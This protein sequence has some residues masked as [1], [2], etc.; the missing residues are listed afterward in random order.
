MKFQPHERIFYDILAPG[1][2]GEMGLHYTKEIGR[3]GAVSGNS[4]KDYS[5]TYRSRILTTYLPIMKNERHM[6]NEIF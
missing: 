3:N 6:P 4:T 5:K 2:I 1:T